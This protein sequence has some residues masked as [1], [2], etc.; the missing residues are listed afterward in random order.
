MTMKDIY[1]LIDNFDTW[2]ALKLCQEKHLI[3]Y[4]D[5]LFECG[6]LNELI[7]YL[8][9]TN[10]KSKW[11]YKTAGGVIDY[12]LIEVLIKSNINSVINDN[13]F[14]KIP[15]EIINLYIINYKIRNKILS[16]DEAIKFLDGVR[17]NFDKYNRNSVIFIFTEI[18]N[19]FENI[20]EWSFFVKARSNI[21]HIL[22]VRF[23]NYI[24]SK[25]YYK[26][27]SQI[28]NKNYLKDI[29]VAIMI[30]GAFRGHYRHCLKAAVN[31]AESINGDIFIC[32]WDKLF[33]YPGLGGAGGNYVSRNFSSIMNDCPDLIKNK[34]GLRKHF[35]NV[36]EILNQEYCE[37]LDKNEFLKYSNTI[38]D[39]ILENEKDF[40]NNTINNYI[41]K[42]KNITQDQLD[43]HFNIYFTNVCKQFYL[44]DKC[45]QTII[46]YEKKHHFKYDYIIRIRPDS[47]P[48]LLNASELLKIQPSEIALNWMGGIEVDDRYVYGRRNEMLQFCNIYDFNKKQE[49]NYFLNMFNMGGVHGMLSNWV[50]LNNLDPI[51]MK[52]L[53]RIDDKYHISYLPN[54]DKELQ[55][56][57]KNSQLTD[58]QLKA[59]IVFFDKIKHL[60]NQNNETMKEQNDINQTA[61]SRIH[62]QLSYKLGQAMIANS[63]S[64]WGYI[65]MPY[66][67]S[68]IKDMHKKEQ[69]A[70]NEKIKAN[71]SLKLP[72]LESYPDYK[73]ALKEKE[74]LTYKLGEAMIEASKNWYKGGYIKLW[75]KCKNIQKECKNDK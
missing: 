26:K 66:V 51:A 14:S 64:I 30:S 31:L 36:F 38:K 56:D 22:K 28:F 68:Y 73:E 55:I 10:L 13:A 35:P 45:C 63:K 39:V 37:P 57:I 4:T 54:F 58:N 20:N 62:N 19:Y 47:I 41:D 75:F 65:R 53:G 21:N 12:N 16:I 32:S 67:L 48:Q 44:L 50:I 59:C 74:C 33:C 23:I 29:K 34:A 72:P 17:I 8:Y 61:K 70:Y 9:N 25:I 49:F 60:I 40:Q 7:S 1:S 71:P 6:L 3:Y 18:F 2:S 27:F 5:M 52:L 43:N 11:E 15:K 24:G 42:I 46:N 69:I